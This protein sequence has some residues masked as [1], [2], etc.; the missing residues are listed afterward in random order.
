MSDEKGVLTMG[1]YSNFWTAFGAGIASPALLYGPPAN[2]AAYVAVLSPAQSF[3]IVG[4]Y[5]SQA[6]KQGQNGEQTGNPKT[7]R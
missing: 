7:V 4:G 3:S 2:Y 1:A 6:M 5:L